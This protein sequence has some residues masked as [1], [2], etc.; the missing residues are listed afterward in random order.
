MKNAANYASL[1]IIAFVLT[2]GLS[3]LPLKKLIKPYKIKVSAKAGFTLDKPWYKINDKTLSYFPESNEID[4]NPN[5]GR[6]SIGAFGCDTIEYN[7][8]PDRCWISSI[9]VVLGCDTLLKGCVNG[10]AKLK[11]TA[12]RLDQTPRVLY[13]DR[14]YT[15]SSGWVQVSLRNYFEECFLLDSNGFA[16]LGLKYNSSKALTINVKKK[17]PNSDSSINVVLTDVDPGMVGQNDN[18]AASQPEIDGD[19]N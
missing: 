10:S 4:I 17:K 11:G 15:V 2:S 1:L 12:R 6:I 8:Q 7:V 9:E 14:N 18:S 3:C 16:A 19:G 5:A 13:S